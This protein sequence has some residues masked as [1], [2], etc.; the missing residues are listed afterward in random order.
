MRC[1]L[2][3]FGFCQQHVATIQDNFNKSNHHYNKND[4]DYCN[5]IFSLH[6]VFSYY[7]LA[8][9]LKRINNNRDNLSTILGQKVVY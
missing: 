8:V 7:L 4:N 3:R 2:K 6:F 5:N 1:V 9:Y